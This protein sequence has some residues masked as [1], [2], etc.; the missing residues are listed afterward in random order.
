[1]WLEL[2][3]KIIFFLPPSSQGEM[4]SKFWKCNSFSSHRL[5]YLLHPTVGQ[6]FCPIRTDTSLKKAPAPFWSNF[7]KHCQYQEHGDCR[8]WVVYY[9]RRSLLYCIVCVVWSNIVCLPSLWDPHEKETFY[10]PAYAR[11]WILQSK[12]NI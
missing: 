12:Y 11:K 7:K 3:P 9:V 6:N 5:S 2:Q 10:L 4:L 8:L 1:M